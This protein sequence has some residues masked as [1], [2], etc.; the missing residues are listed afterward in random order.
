MLHMPANPADNKEQSYLKTYQTAVAD[1]AETMAAREQL[2]ARRE[3][4]DRRIVRLRDAV[5]GLGG[6]CL[7]SSESI[8]KEYPELFP[9]QITPEVG[10]TD[11][12]RAVFK[13]NPDRSLSPVYI[14]DSLEA[15]GFD[16]DKYKNVLA[17]I[18]SIVKR[19]RG[20]GDVLVDTRDG[21]TV[22]R[23]NPR[24]ELAKEPDPDDI[25][26]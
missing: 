21:R 11:A 10:F 19:L 12:V 26:F 3:E 5:L 2:D 8:A 13:A 20:K 24:G 16:I 6:L 4:L 23:L 7:K 9:D 22:Y 18:H 1:L 15:S 25:P 14:R 17:S